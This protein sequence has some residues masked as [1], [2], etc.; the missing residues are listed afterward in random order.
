[1][2]SLLGSRLVTSLGLLL[3]TIWLCGLPHSMARAQV[4]PEAVD[5]LIVETTRAGLDLGT[6]TTATVDLP[7]NVTTTTITGGTRPAGGPNLFHSFDSFSVGTKDIAHFQNDMMLPTTNIIARVIGDASGLR[8]ASTIDGI[9]RTNN[10]LSLNDPLNFGAANLFLVNPAGVIFGPN[11]QLDI[12][13]S[14]AATTADYLRMSDG[15]LF[16]TDPAQPS[17]LSIANVASFGFTSPRPVAISIQESF[18]QVATG[19]TISVVGGDID[20]VGLNNGDPFTGH[21][22]LEASSGRINLASVASPGEVIPDTQGEPANL[23]VQSFERLG[24]IT[25][26][27]D[28]VIDVAGDPAGTIFVRGQQL[29]LDQSSLSASTEGATD[30]PGMAVD[31][32]VRGDV[33]LMGGSVNVAEIGASSFGAGDTGA[34]RIVADSLQLLGGVNLFQLANIGSRSFSTAVDAGN[35]NT[36]DIQANRVLLGNNAFIQTRTFGPGNAGNI[37]IT[38]GSLEASGTQSFIDVSTR[39]SG[40][41]GTLRVTSDQIELRDGGLLTGSTFGGASGRGGNIE[42]ETNTLTISGRDP[43]GSS[44]GIFSNTVF[45]GAGSAGDIR[46]TTTGDVALSNFGIIS[47]FSNSFGNAGRI[48]LSVG[49]NLSVTSG[50]FISSANFGAGAAGDINVTARNVLLQGPTTPPLAF[51]TPGIFTLG[52]VQATRAGNLTLKTGNL[53]ILDG[54]MLIARTNGPGPGGTI[55]ITADRVTISGSDPNLFMPEGTAS[56]IYAGTRI[57]NPNVPIFVQLATGNAGNIN[58]RSGLVELGN[59]GTIEAL[60]D[61]AGNAG[62]IAITTPTLSLDDA[63]S[64]TAEARRQGN[65]GSI[66]L[67][68]DTLTAQGNSEISSSST[69]TTAGAGR[70]GNI[71]VQGVASPATS[72]SLTNSSLLTS[73]ASDGAGGSIMVDAGTITLNNATVSASVKDVPAGGDPLAGVASITLNSPVVSITGGAVTAA[74]S[75]SR[76]AGNINLLQLDNLTVLSGGRIEASTSGAGVGGSITIAATGDVTVSGVSTDGQ[77]RS[78]IFAKTQTA[79]SGTGAGG[80]SGGGGGGGTAVKPGNAGNITIAS[81]NLL[82]TGGAQIDS[83]TTSGGA[84]GSVSITTAENIT[85]AGSSTRLTSDAT[86]GDGKGGSITLVAKNITVRDAASVTAATGGKGDAGNVTLTALGQLLLQSA[87]T[88]T[89][90]T[91]GSG[92]GGTIVIQASQVLLDGP[93]TGIAADTLRPFADMTITINIL[94]PNDGDLVVQLDSPTGTR[95]ALLSRVGGSGDNF[96]GT[97]FNDQATT[98]I[99][100]GS[101]PFTGTFTPREPLGQLITELVAGNW[102]LNVRDQAT[103]NSPGTLESWTLQIGTQTFQSTGGSKEIPDNGN[104]RSTIT[105]AAPTVPTVQG[106]GEAPGIGGNVTVN[107]GTVTVRN[108]ATMSA[109]TRGSGQ[110]GTLTV[111]ATGPVALAGSGSGLFTDSEA[112]GAGGNINV[113]AAHMTMDNGA[114]VSAASSSTG[115][116]GTITIDAGSEFLSTNSSITTEA[117][118]ASGGNITLL[119]TD[120]IRLR[121]SQISASVFGGPATAGGNILIDPNFIILQNSQII[122]Q[123]FQG[124]GGNINL[125]FNQAL[126]RDARSTISASSEFGVNGTVNINSPAQNLSGA[127]VPLEQSFLSGNTISNQR[128]AARMAQGQ[129]STFIVTEREGLPQE[130]GGMLMSSLVEIDGTASSETIEP[131]RV[132]SVSQSF[133]TPLTSEPVQLTWTDNTCRR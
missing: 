133:F 77:T 74:T 54:A 125:T 78:G 72:V 73:V 89:T 95:V 52:G 2:T 25:V 24:N 31:V 124:A 113:Q 87:G 65:A 104:V 98:L 13:G 39:G 121:D 97:Q 107:A 66:T 17:V 93:G 112:S 68:V 85:I 20:I 86:R 106:I 105:V 18:L 59:R 3:T 28:A 36:I 53:D 117:S 47:G 129:I 75:G 92:K 90:S 38:A 45:P 110:G 103:G 23:N 30:H 41:G 101:A 14:F 84:G 37:N 120:M 63:A 102:T 42:V 122:A 49:G 44:S 35:G 62:N 96:T 33:V 76:N 12:K 9:L 58:I 10:P 82:L 83:S 7:T 16:H 99:T 115:D 116:A 119:A 79:S 81:K 108:G 109:T 48:D 126:L 32:Q 67:N 1:M 55:D 22:V 11:A 80:G 51:T 111:N 43:S 70:A 61:S 132:A 118:Q 56:G 27:N 34:V 128:C 15:A 50:A 94:H 19:Q 46:I 57:L 5:T 88:I 114:T 130:P 71:I 29:V 21:V 64:I 127:L 123:A 26:R 60:S 131:I 40:R 4:P 8:Q 91:S 6:R 100:S 69:R